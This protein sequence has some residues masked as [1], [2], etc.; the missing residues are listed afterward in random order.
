VPLTS[1][2]KAVVSLEMLAAVT[3]IPYEVTQLAAVLQD[4][5][6]TSAGASAGANTGARE[7]AGVGAGTSASLD[8][9]DTESDAPPAHAAQASQVAVVVCPSCALDAHDADAAFCKR[10]GSALYAKL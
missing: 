5:P 2:G 9:V 3:V 1:A 8:E 4:S 6:S 10:C 7:G